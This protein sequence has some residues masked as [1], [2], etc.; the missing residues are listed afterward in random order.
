M[1]LPHINPSQILSTYRQSDAVLIVC[2]NNT[3]KAIEIMAINDEAARVTGYSNEMLISKPLATILPER[4]SSTLSE[5]IGY[6]EEEG[7]DDLLIVLGKVRSFSIKTIAGEEVEFKLRIIRGES[8]DHNPWFHLILID[9]EKLRKANAFREMLRENF[10]GHEILD[11]N[12]GLPNRASI[13][14]NLELVIYHVRDK[15]ISASFA[16]IDINK[17]D[18]LMQ[19][20]GPEICNKLYRHIAHICKLKLRSEDSIGMLSERSLAVILVDSVQ[21]PSRMVLNRLRWAI[22]VTPL[23]LGKKDLLAQVNIGFTQ[24]DGQIRE[25]D[26]LE[27]CESFMQGQRDK[28][29]NNV[30]LIVTHERRNYP[31]VSDRRK[32]TLPVAV[33]RRKRDRRKA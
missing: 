22:G 23:E 10:Q 17:Y 31:V 32:T 7:D 26:I 9:E 8:V 15:E 19:E 5:F 18:V 12:T 1:A 28:I 21:E 14:K 27:K 25:G 16:V 20:Q 4:I 13:L 30:Q 11:D 3:T 2:Q 33:E 29:N 6:E 24:L